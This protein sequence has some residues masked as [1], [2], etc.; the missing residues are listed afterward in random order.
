LT[1]AQK[2]DQFTPE[3]LAASYGVT[4]GDAQAMLDREHMQRRLR[5]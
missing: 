2:L 3:G 1:Y 4:V 5:G